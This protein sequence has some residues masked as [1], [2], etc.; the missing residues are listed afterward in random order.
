MYGMKAAS[1]AMIPASWA[2]AMTGQVGV[3]LATLASGF[4]L[5]AVSQLLRR[6]KKQH[7]P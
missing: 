1:V 4:M 3:A 5:V 7:L 6:T 2:A